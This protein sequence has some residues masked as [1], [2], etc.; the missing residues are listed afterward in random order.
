MQL[1]Q[2]QL[3][4]VEANPNYQ[5]ELRMS[6]LKESSYWKGNNGVGLT[7]PELVEEWYRKRHTAEN[8]LSYPNSSIDRAYWS[9]RSLTVLSDLDIADITEASTAD[10]IVEAITD[11]Q[12]QTLASS[13]FTEEAKKVLF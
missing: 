13:A 7:T 8:L 9:A 6:V 4:E 2:E 12:W 5:N 3:I 1:T 10:E 11:P